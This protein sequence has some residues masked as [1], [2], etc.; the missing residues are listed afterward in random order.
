MQFSV[1]HPHIHPFLDIWRFCFP[2]GRFCSKDGSS[3][4][5]MLPALLLY[6][7]VRCSPQKH[8]VPELLQFPAAQTPPAQTPLSSPPQLPTGFPLS[9]P[10]RKLLSLPL[11]KSPRWQ[12]SSPLQQFS[13]PALPHKQENR[14][15]VRRKWN[16]AP[17]QQLKP[18]SALHLSLIH[19]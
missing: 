12:L 9:L 17:R 2:I 1:T 3:P 6:C 19:I 7:S 10:L 16:S 11:Q 8:P 14:L 15:S 18:P 5:F 4:V 13:A